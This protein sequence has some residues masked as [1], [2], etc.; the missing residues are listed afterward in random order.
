MPDALAVLQAKKTLDTMNGLRSLVGRSQ[1]G[2]A[3]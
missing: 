1:A 2:R 3:T